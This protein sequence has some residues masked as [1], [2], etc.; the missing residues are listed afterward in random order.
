[1]LRSIV[2]LLLIATAFGSALEPPSGR[3]SS[4]RSRAAP[5]TPAPQTDTGVWEEFGLVQSE[6]AEYVSDSRRFTASA[7]RFRDPTGAMA[8]FQWQRPA[9]ATPSSSVSLA[10]ETPDAVVL[11]FHNYLLRL[12]GWKP[13]GAEL[14]PLLEVLPQ[15]DQSSLPTLPGYLPAAGRLPTRSGTC[16]ARLRWPGSSRASRLRWRRFTSEPRRNWSQYKSPGRQS[17]PG[18][19]LLSDAELRPGARRRVFQASRGCGQAERAVGRRHP[20]SVRSERSRATAGQG[21]VPGHDHLERAA[22][23]GA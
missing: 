9:G 2:V 4:D 19:V 3:S 21:A 14:A 20:V 7:W 15:L 18:R 1:M 12:D 13:E 16:S 10:A 5:L 6:T 11:A 17:Q 22:S 23:H 8:A